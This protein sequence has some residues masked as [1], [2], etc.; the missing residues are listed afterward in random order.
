MPSNLEKCFNK[1]LKTK[2]IVVF[3]EEREEIFTEEYEEN[4][5]EKRDNFFLKLCNRVIAIAKFLIT[6]L[7]NLLIH[8]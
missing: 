4:R 2:K 8:A 3:R 5:T 7:Q 6:R 1:S